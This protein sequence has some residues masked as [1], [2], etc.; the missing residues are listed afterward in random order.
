[1]I[2]AFFG[3]GAHE[4]GYPNPVCARERVVGSTTET[5]Q[6]NSKRKGDIGITGVLGADTIVLIDFTVSDG[7]GSKPGATYLPDAHRQRNADAKRDNYVGLESTVGV[8]V[9]PRLPA[10]PLLTQGVFRELMTSP[11]AQR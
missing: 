7:G 9:N 1:M 4:P 10:P 2:L 11:T 3:S 6:Q 8:G 5:V